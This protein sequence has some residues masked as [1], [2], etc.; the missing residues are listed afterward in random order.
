MNGA[1]AQIVALTCHGNAFL[2]GRP[3]GRFFPDNSTCLFCDEIVFSEVNPGMPSEQQEEIVASSPDR[4]FELLQKQGTAG[5]QIF[6]EPNK[7]RRFNERISL[8]SFKGGGTWAIEAVDFRGRSHCWVSRWEVMKKKSI[9]DNMWKLIY[10]MVPEKTPGETHVANLN[11][12]S[13]RLRESLTAIRAFA[14]TH[15]CR[16][17]FDLF[18]K[19]LDALNADDD[20]WVGYHQDLAPPGILGKEA[21]RILDACQIAWVFDRMGPWNN[22]KIEGEYETEYRQVS[23]ALFGAIVE[24]ILA[25]VNES[26]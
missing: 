23:D 25:S 12:V 15:D 5:V 21:I 18:S 26:Y 8:A 9:D 17:F 11:I 16:G 7:E 24:G 1:I 13:Q 14:Q 20:A 4:W 2:H 22:L 19:A 3:V 6:Y 10:F